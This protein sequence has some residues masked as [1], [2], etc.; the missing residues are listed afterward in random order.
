MGATACTGLAQSGST[1]PPWA[2]GLEP[3]VSA[4]HCS[5]SPSAPQEG[6]HGGT[7]DP[8]PLAPMGLRSHAPCP[9]GWAGTPTPAM[10]QGGPWPWG[11][12][13]GVVESRAGGLVGSCVEPRGPCPGLTRSLLILLTMKV[14]ICRAYGWE[15]RFGEHTHKMKSVFFSCRMWCP[16]NKYSREETSGLSV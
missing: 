2:A 9:E 6:A 1:C 5:S 4:G 14:I 3:G 16:A 12:E 10:G 13:P 7:A 8:D 11:G 15:G